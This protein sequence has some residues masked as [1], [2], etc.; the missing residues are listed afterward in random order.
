MAASK[1]NNIFSFEKMQIIFSF[2]HTVLSLYIISP[3]FGSRPTT[4]LPVIA[5]ALTFKL[6]HFVLT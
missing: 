4:F 1:N 2:P 6:G 3:E 5:S